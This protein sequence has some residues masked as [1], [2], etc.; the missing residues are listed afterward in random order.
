M[1]CVAS[2]ECLLSAVY[3]FSSV[4]LPETLNAAQVSY[5]HGLVSI[6]CTADMSVCITDISVV[7]K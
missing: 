6:R 5:V 7:S 2:D 4:A 1:L 3:T